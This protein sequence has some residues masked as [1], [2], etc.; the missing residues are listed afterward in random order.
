MNHQKLLE[1]AKDARKNA[2]VPYSGFA[3]GAAVMTEDGRIFTGTNVENASYG[4]TVCAERIA[5]FQA[6]SQG[7]TRFTG[8]AVVAD[9]PGPTSPC[10]ACR[11][12][13]S[14]FFSSQTPITMGNIKGETITKTMASI[15]PDAFERE[16]LNV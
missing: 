2:Y 6:V 12:V 14:E 9:S 10:G 13:M 11:Q 4:L 7:Y 5:I 3:V 15:L 1:A 16:D 8:L